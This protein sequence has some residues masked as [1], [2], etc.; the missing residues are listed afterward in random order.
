MNGFWSWILV[1]LFVGCGGEPA[2]ELCDVDGDGV[3]GYA[4]G[5]TDCDDTDKLTFPG[6]D[7]S[8]DGVD[9]NCDGWLHRDA[10]D[11]TLVYVD[12]DGD[13]YGDPLTGQLACQPSWP[14]VGNADDCN[15]TDATINPDTIWYADSDGDGLGDPLT[16]TTACEQPDG[17]VANAQD[18][19]DSDPTTAGCWTDITVGRNHS[20]AIKTDG[21]LVCWGSDSDGQATPP[22][23]TNF[24]QVTAG[25][26]YTCALDGVTQQASC[27]GSNTYGE[28]SPPSSAF[29]SIS[30]GL[31]V[32]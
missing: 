14:D 29:S 3:D 27:W 6:A 10:V 32:C 7:E 19:D 24:I 4:C 20:C 12:A 26:R 22:T 2:V 30:C 25:Y 23:G 11:G 13:G 9:H 31:N 21:S 28:T 8:C 5:G 16:T 1:S 18:G 17:Y 15:D